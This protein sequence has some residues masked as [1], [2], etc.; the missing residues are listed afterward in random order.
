MTGCDGAGLGPPEE[1]RLSHDSSVSELV[2]S[3]LCNAALSKICSI[4]VTLELLRMITSKIH[5]R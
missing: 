1:A 2:A 3:Q 5:S 4:L